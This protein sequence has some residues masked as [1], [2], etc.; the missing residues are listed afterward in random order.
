L[1]AAR[2]A[3]LSPLADAWKLQR[4]MLDHLETIWREPDFGIWEVR[5]EKRHFT[6]SK[7]MCWVAFDRAIKSCEKSDLEGP[8]ERWRKIRETIFEEICSRGFDA[9]RNTFVQSYG[10]EA[11]DAAV[12]LMPQVGFLPADDPRV[13]GTVAAIEKTLMKDG[14]VL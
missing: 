7:L 13:I 10:H 6:H 14:L 12:L 8:V 9:E 1:H 3:D 11:L 5:G 2:E 4:V